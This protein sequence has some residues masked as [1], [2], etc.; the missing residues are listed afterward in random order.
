YAFAL[1]LCPHGRRSSPYMNY[2]GIT[3]HLCSSLNN[4]LPEWQAGHRQVVLLGLDQDLD[5]I[6]RMS[7]SLS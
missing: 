6:H 7:L 3:F 4:G 5:V 1:Q 2:M